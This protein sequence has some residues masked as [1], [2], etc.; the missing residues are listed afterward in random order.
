MMFENKHKICA[1]VVRV[2]QRQTYWTIQDNTGMCGT[3]RDH[4]GQYGKF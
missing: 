3:I 1:E 2:E 4:T